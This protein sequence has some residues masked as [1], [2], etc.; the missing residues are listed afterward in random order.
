MPAMSLS[1]ADHLAMLEAGARRAGIKYAR[2]EL[3]RAHRVTLGGLRLR[4][5]DWGGGAGPPVVFLHGGGL[6]AHAWDLVC[7]AMRARWHCIA[8]EQRGH[9]DSDWAPDADYSLSSLAGDA[10]AFLRH[11]GEGP[12]ALV[13]HSMGALAAMLAVARH[14]ELVAAL[15]IVDVGP[16][17]REEGADAIRALV[18]GGSE[19]D[20]LDAAVAAARRFNPMRSAESLRRSLLLNLKQLPDGRWRWKYD[21]RRYPLLRTDEYRAE[22]RGLWQALAQVR[23]PA[24]VVHGGRSRIFLAEDA[25]RVADTMADGRMVTIEDAGHNVHSDAPRALATALDEFLGASFRPGC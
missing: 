5:V 9:G 14:P 7:L 1:A 8:L 3:P 18:A 22:R 15:A 25:R 19:F 20:S 16:E 17:P 10:V 23:C 6:T 24:L 13:G 11:L 21:D 4:Y 2:L 12:V